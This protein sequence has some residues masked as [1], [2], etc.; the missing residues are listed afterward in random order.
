MGR[1]KSKSYEEQLKEKYGD[2]IQNLEPYVNST[3]KIW[4]I[5]NKHDYKYFSTPSSV[6]SSKC[7]CP[8]CGEESHA[9]HTKARMAYTDEEYKKLLDEK[10]NGNI[11]C[12]E[13]VKGTNTS[14]K[15]FCKMLRIS[16]R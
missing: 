11:I 12:L 16:L 9:S 15:H 6:L 4:H 1:P 8:K 10:F 3:T 14:I 7:G 2:K 13:S 5:C